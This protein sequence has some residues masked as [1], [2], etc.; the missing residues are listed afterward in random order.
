MT[1]IKSCWFFSET[2]GVGSLLNH[3]NAITSAVRKWNSLQ[4][5]CIKFHQLRK[6]HE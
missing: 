3:L 5:H 4:Q 1:T 6:T 2:I